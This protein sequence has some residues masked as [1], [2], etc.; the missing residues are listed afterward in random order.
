MGEEYVTDALFE[1]TILTHYGFNPKTYFDN[2]TKRMVF[3]F[4]DTTGNLAESILNEFWNESKEKRL[5]ETFRAVKRMA[6]AENYQKGYYAG[7]RER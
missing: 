3:I 6:V 7:S 2:E 5:L 1:A 4:R